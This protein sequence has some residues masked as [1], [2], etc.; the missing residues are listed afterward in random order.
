M[1][2]S[3]LDAATLGTDLDLSHLGRLG[4][5]AVFSHTAPHEVAARLADTDVAVINKIRINAENLSGNSRLKM[6]AEC[7]TGYDNIDLAVC[8]EKGIAVANVVGYST[9]SV[10]QLTLAMALSLSTNLKA[11]RH[12]VDSGAYTKGGVANCLTPVFHELNGKTWG[13]VGYGNIGAQVAKVASALGCRVLAFSK[14]PKTGVEN[15]TLD[16]L[17]KQSDIISVHLPLTPE[18]RGIIGAR[19]LA[20]MKRDAIL[21]NV[22]R[23]AVTDEQA[24]AEA[25]L[26]GRLGGLGVDVYSAEPF[27]AEHPF[28]A[29]LGR[30]NVCLT[31]HMAWGAFEAR[32][33]CLA[34]VAENIAAFQRGER[35]NRID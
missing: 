14:S 11:F 26:E 19:E 34:E 24:L 13:I 16:M 3:V 9:H 12:T 25:V 22:A 20:M 33:R 6:I 5:L 21:I 30:D 8:R 28:T 4:E 27:T 17:C 29:L 2:I 10:A 18:T 23:G 15:A 1:K 35:R 31:P 32:T 7:A